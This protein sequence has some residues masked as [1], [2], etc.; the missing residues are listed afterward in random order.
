MNKFI[1]LTE[2]YSPNNYSP[3]NIVLTEGKGAHVKDSEG[4]TYIDCVS[5]FSVL[6]HGH[7][8]PKIIQAFLD[9][10][11]KI[12]MTSRALYS[13]NL[14]IWEEKICKLANKNKV[15]PMNTGTE[16]VET[17]IKV[18][19][20]WSQDVKGLNANEA[21]IIAMEGNFHGRTIGSL[22][23]SSN[24]SYKEGFGILAGNMKYS[25]FGNVEQVKS[26]ITPQT[27]A[28]IL[29]PIQGEGGVN[30]PPANFIKEVKALC[31][32]NNIL[33]IADEIQVGLGR[34]GKLFAMEWEGV[35]PDIYLLG[36]ALGGGLYPISAIV[37]NDDVMQVL[38][39]GTHGSTFGG[40]PLACAVSIAA[41]DVLVDDN[42]SERSNVLGQ[43]LL[44][45]LQA[46][47]SP[48][49]KEVRGRGLFIGLE[50][51]KNAQETVSQINQQGVLCK[52]TQGNI[53]RLAPPLIIEEN[54]IDTI[55]D[56]IKKVIEK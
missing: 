18:A 40:N 45:G 27:A 12:T 34:T 35:E 19:T 10:S 23:L 55:I 7:C 33:L 56:V 38:T 25:E 26:Q 49:I 9:Q 29:E 39:P 24:D 3:L 31:E 15:L 46:I 14:G 21:E 5:G 52:E 30:I 36:K 20:K 42:L 1:E 17:A 4:N 44:K 54:D 2:Q 13:D 53:I 32:E 43:K 16:A 37:A 28:I 11:Q 48:D 47:D 51:N 41:L 8:H 6:N 22:S 50:L